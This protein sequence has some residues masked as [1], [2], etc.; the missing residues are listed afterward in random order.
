VL[1]PAIDAVGVSRRLGQIVADMEKARGEYLG[2]ADAQAVDWAIQNARIV[3]QYAQLAAGQVSR[4]ESMARN[5]KWILDTAPK[6][7]RIVLWAHNGHVARMDSGEF[8]AMGAYLNE[9]YGR[10]HVVVGFA[11]NRGQYT[12]MGGGTGLGT[13]PLAPGVVGSYEHAFAQAGMPRFI[14][15]LRVARA[16]DPSSGWLHTPMKLRSIGAL[17]MDQQFQ[18]ANLGSVFDLVVFLEETT[19]TR[20]VAS[21]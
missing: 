2:R 10:D 8:R 6:G 21:Q 19:P 12:A 15:D 16:G 17:A 14:L 3:H 1:T 5:V 7:T 18:T 4:D 9:W 13:H 11:L 20:R